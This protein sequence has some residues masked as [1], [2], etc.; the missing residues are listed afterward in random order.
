MNFTDGIKKTILN[1]FV[2]EGVSSG[3]IVVILLITFL[4]SLY[5]F[6]VY[7][8]L[9]KS[10][11][12]D[13]NYHISLPLV[14]I[15]TAGIIIAM[16]SSIVISL[17]MVGAL[18]IVRF[19]TAVK[20]SM[21]LVFLFWAIGNGIICGAGLFELSIMISVMI[22]VGIL[23]LEYIPLNK[24]PYLLI[25]NSETDN[26]DNILHIIHEYCNGHKVISRNVKKTGTDYILEV[27]TKK[28]KEMVKALSAA[29]GIVNVS[30]LMNEG[31]V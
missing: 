26:E 22:T 29:E 30:L 27:R 5:I 13:K 11:L 21:D 9:V 10:S 31:K 15:I 4:I 14:S 8:F 2:N 12:Y 18:S 20:D 25:I 19:R 28:E 3:Q 24:K 23:L 16:Q 7:K 1:G 6:M 17:G